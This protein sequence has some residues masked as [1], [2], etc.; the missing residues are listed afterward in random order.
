[1][2][3]IDV[4]IKKTSTKFCGHKVIGYK[5]IKVDDGRM[6]TYFTDKS[7]LLDVISKINERAINEKYGVGWNVIS[8]DK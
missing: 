5:V 1:M 4:A 2:F 3:T 8:E 7:E 6:L